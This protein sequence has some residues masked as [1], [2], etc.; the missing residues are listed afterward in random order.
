V[1]QGI[2]AELAADMARLARL[3][4]QLLEA[5]DAD[6]AAFVN[7]MEAQ[8]SARSSGERAAFRAAL[9]VAAASPLELAGTTLAVLNV[10]VNRV[11][12][13]APFAASDLVAAAALAGGAI[14]AALAMA[15]VNLAL[16]RS[17]RDPALDGALANMEQTR[18]RIAREA[19][20]ALEHLVE[21]TRVDHTK[22]GSV[23]DG[24]A[25]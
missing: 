24:E 2:Q 19:A 10:A 7:L 15:D 18:A 13:A 14:D 25:S 20:A 4:D 6:I 17:E 12:N 16:M 8:R 23:S 21:S 11:H 1:N 22:E 3:K 9:Q 5:S